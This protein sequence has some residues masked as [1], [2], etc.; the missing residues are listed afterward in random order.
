[1]KYFSS[2][3]RDHSRGSVGAAG[4]D[5]YCETVNLHKAM[6]HTGFHGAIPEGTFGLAVPRSSTGSKKGLVLRNTVGVIDSDYRGEILLAY[7]SDA[8]KVNPM[9][10][11][12]ERV[13]QLI[14][15]PF[16]PVE[17]NKVN[18]YSDL[19]TTDRGAGGFG[20]TG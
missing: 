12:G 7:D 1:M 6:I 9:T 3:G 17:L 5:L 11:I 10:L 20:S 18:D 2:A 19:D 4:I 8:L 14:I 16:C 13:A 15:L